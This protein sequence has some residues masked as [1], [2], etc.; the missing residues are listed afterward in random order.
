MEKPTD[1]TE[2]L[3]P[4]RTPAHALP[5]LIPGLAQAIAGGRAIDL[6]LP[7]HVPQDNDVAGAL[8]V[9]L[10]PAPGAKDLLHDLPAGQTH[11]LLRDVLQYVKDYR[12]LLQAAFAKL[13]TDG[14]LVITV[15]HQFLRERKFMRPS[16]YGGGPAGHVIERFYTPASLLF[17]VQEALDPASYRVRLLRDDDHD[18]E[19]QAPLERLPA[20]SKRIVLA[21]QKI[22]RPAWADRM[23]DTDDPRNV[24]ARPERVVILN[25]G[26]PVK[27]FVLSSS[28]ASIDQ[29]LVLKLDHIGDFIHG[30]Q[31]MAELRALFP[32]ATITLI[33]S[34]W[35]RATALESGLFDH[36]L[37]FDFMVTDASAGNKEMPLMTAYTKMKNILNDRKFD[38]AIDLTFDPKARPLLE[39]VSARH[40]A[41]LDRWNDYPF[42]D[43]KLSI[44][45]PTI[46][47][48]A[49]K[50]MIRPGGFFTRKGVHKLY[51]IDV[52][53]RNVPSEL[54]E[55]LIW[56]PYESL[57]PGEYEFEVFV[58]SLGGAQEIGF[59]ICNKSGTEVLF[60][61]VLD[62][63][64][65]GFPKF[66]LS[67]SEHVHDLEFRFYTNNNGPLNFRFL[68][69]GYSR[70]GEIIG[71]HQSELMYLLVHLTAARL[72]QPYTAQVLPA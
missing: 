59:D 67:L 21:L 29:I 10:A 5:R 20:G 34:S 72:R 52:M 61:G 51:A 17:E 35:N 48:A 4:T 50:G 55:T 45:S 44:H 33:C 42:L 7:G 70:R 38:L 6:G 22:T 69:I 60:G 12:G 1:V 58:E 27:Q 68:G 18:Y 56:G 32:S 19:Y 31:A 36:I 9:L 46:D 49:V 37:L 30:R 53:T 14:W 66:S 41:G 65:K 54:G 43:I 62:I 8:A 47:A 64:E 24:L 25:G 63:R 15:P 3:V 71:I 57:R 39:C 11:V 16:R 26:E 23:R 13:A 28:S 2:D 40:K